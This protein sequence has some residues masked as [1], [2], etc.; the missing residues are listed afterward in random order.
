MSANITKE[1]TVDINETEI[2]LSPKSLEKGRLKLMC[3][4]PGRVF[5]RERLCG[6]LPF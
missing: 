6:K 1:F 4:E 3:A 2:T 5:T